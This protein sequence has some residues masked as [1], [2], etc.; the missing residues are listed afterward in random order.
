M[1]GSS[2]RAGCPPGFPPSS[3][4]LGRGRGTALATG[5]PR[6]PPGSRPDPGTHKPQIAGEGWLCQ[7]HTRQRLQLSSPSQ[8]VSAVHDCS[9]FGTLASKPQE[10]KTRTKTPFPAPQPRAQQIERCRCLGGRVRG[11]SERRGTCQ[12]LRASPSARPGRPGAAPAPGGSQVRPGT[13][14]GTG[15]RPTYRQLRCPFPCT[16][17]SKRL[18]NRFAARN[19]LIANG[20]H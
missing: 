9:H 2:P 10:H 1:V 13:A 19:M 16:P 5:R 20:A 7:T 8:D 17:L 4:A 12:R 3:D 6:T 18:S 14:P 11:A 15:E